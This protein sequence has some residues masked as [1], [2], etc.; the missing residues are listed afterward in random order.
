MRIRN[1]QSYLTSMPEGTAP[2]NPAKTTTT[3]LYVA[4]LIAIVGYLCFIAVN[5]LLYIESRGQVEVGRYLIHAT[6]TG[7]IDEILVKQGEEVSAG[8]LLVSLR[9]PPSA[10][11]RQN[12]EQFKASRDLDLKKAEIATLEQ[13]STGLLSPTPP[14]AVLPASILK[15]DNDLRMKK[16]ELALFSETL[17]GQDKG[18]GQSAEMKRAR[19]L[20][21]TIQDPTLTATADAERLRLL[22][23]IASAQREITALDRYRQEMLR[24]EQQALQIKIAAIK[25]EVEPL[26]SYLEALQQGEAYGVVSERLLSPING[27]VQAIFKVS[28][29]QASSGEPLLALRAPTAM[30]TVHGYFN[31]EQLPILQNNKQVRILFADGSTS[32]GRISNHYSI[33]A[34]YR[35]KLKNG[36]IPIKS[37]VLVEIVPAD[38]NDDVRWRSF[39]RMDVT[40]RVRR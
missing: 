34:S 11:Q 30:V 21:L 29:E 1:R 3:R 13:V 23:R 20:E 39:D 25:G 32:Q 26:L 12:T 4:F 2:A 16:I 35:E 9:P 27:D 5:K 31:E 14:T 15:L 10:P 33:A 18:A 24:A 6:G 17:Q 37:A 8:Q 38:P 7:T 28:G 19:L 22:A 40:I 36:Y